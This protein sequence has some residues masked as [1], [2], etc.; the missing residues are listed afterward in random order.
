MM[1]DGEKRAFAIGIRYVL[2]IAV[3]I[4]ALLL[5]HFASSHFHDETFSE[6]G[7][8]ENIQF[9]LLLAS[10]IVFLAH[11]VI[12]PK[13]RTLLFLLSGLCA[14]GCC[15][16]MDNIMDRLIPVMSWRVGFLFVVAPAIW[17][18]MRRKETLSALESFLRSRCFVKLC[19]AFTVILVLGQ[20]IGHRSYLKAVLVDMD[21]IGLVKE[22]IEES[23]ETIGY[24]MILL[25]SLESFLDLAAA[26]DAGE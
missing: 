8:V 9:L 3:C 23:V 18:L 22:V 12:R 5:Q 15:R 16:E 19:N 14:L 10:A 13:F 25:A 1:S 11:G 24:T 7:L 6:N 17:A 4:G 21:H 26:K 20:L 2:Y